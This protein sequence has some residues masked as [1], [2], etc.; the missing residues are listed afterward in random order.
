MWS[1]KMV[2]PSSQNYTSVETSIF[3]LMNKAEFKKRKSA[4]QVTLSLR[5][6]NDG[7]VTRGSK[8]PL[9]NEYGIS[10]LTMKN[11]QDTHKKSIIL[12]SQKHSF[13]NNPTSL[14]LPC[15]PQHLPHILQ[16]ICL[17]ISSDSLWNKWVEPSPKRNIQFK[18]APPRLAS[19]QPKL[20]PHPRR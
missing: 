13:Q 4:F 12:S 18:D 7:Q 19:L 16:I 15:L 2:K 14:H 8:N 10:I 11:N 3:R 6:S 20:A 17:G 9:W 5:W 1:R